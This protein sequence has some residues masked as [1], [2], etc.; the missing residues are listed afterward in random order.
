M[1]VLDKATGLREERINNENNIA[2][3]NNA[4]NTGST[5]Q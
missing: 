4:N 1:S 3:P 2:N 5:N